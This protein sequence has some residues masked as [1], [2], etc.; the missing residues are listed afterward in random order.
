[1]D[2]KDHCDVD[3][4]IKIDSTFST[5]GLFLYTFMVFITPTCNIR[6]I[7]VKV[8]FLRAIDKN[9][10]PCNFASG[11]FDPKYPAQK[12]GSNF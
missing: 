4:A 11:L 12:R 8:S 10:F 7:K 1:M 5:D 3:V 6:G 9:N 2:G